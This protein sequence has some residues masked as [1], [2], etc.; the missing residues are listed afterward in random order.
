MGHKFFKDRFLL[1]IDGDLPDEEYRQCRDHFKA[2]SACR[3]QLEALSLLWREEAEAPVDVPSV[4]LRAG[5]HAAL[6]G[7]TQQSASEPVMAQ[8]AY[9][10]RPALMAATLI[11]GV[12]IGG[13]IGRMSTT[14]PQDEP[15]VAA[16]DPENEPTATYME[17]FQD[18]PPESVGR[19]YMM[20]TVD[21]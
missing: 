4:R 19:A 14:A 3:Q 5:L 20:V 10:L 11:I 12:L 6:R 21:E 8:L 18:L 16:N 13:Y 9:V 2:C 15:A 17:S 7:E 1:Y